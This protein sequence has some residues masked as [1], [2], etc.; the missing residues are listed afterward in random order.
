M[1]WVPNEG[2]AFGQPKVKRLGYALQ[3]VFMAC[4]KTDLYGFA[5]VKIHTSEMRTWLPAIQVGKRTRSC[6]IPQASSPP[7]CASSVPF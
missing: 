3:L 2:Y 6:A 1:L 5:V 7:S 4:D